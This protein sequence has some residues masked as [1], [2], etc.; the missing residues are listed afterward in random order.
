[1]VYNAMIEAFFV[2]EMP[3]LAISLLDEMIDTSTSVKEPVVRPDVSTLSDFRPSAP[4]T[5]SPSTFSTII[6]GFCNADDTE[7]AIVWFKR[8]LSQKHSPRGI[9][10]STLT[11]TRPGSVKQMSLNEL[12]TILKQQNLEEID[13]LE[14]RTVDRALIF[15]ANMKKVQE[16]IDADEKLKA[17]EHLDRLLAW[18]MVDPTSMRHDQMLQNLFK[19]FYDAAQQIPLENSRQRANILLRAFV[20][21]VYANY[22]GGLP[23]DEGLLLARLVSREVIPYNPAQAAELLHAYATEGAKEKLSNMDLHDLTTLLGV[24][25]YLE[26]SHNDPVQRGIRNY[27]FQGLFSLLTD[28]PKDKLKDVFTA[29]RPSTLLEPALQAHGFDAVREW[30]AHLDPSF[31]A[32]LDSVAT[33]QASE[34]GESVSSLP[35]SD[36]TAPTS[37]TS[38]AAQVY[39]APKYFVDDSLTH[40]LDTYLYRQLDEHSLRQ[41]C[42]TLVKAFLDGLNRQVIPSPHSVGKLCA[43]LGRIGDIQSAKMI[44]NRMQ[45]VIATTEGAEQAEIWFL[46]EDSMLIALAQAGD[47]DGAHESQMHNVV[48]NQYL[49]NNI[50]S[51]LA[52]ARK[53]EQALVLFKEM[54]AKDITPSSITY[55]ALIGACARVG[56]VESAENLFEEMVMQPKFKPR[57]PPYNT[58]MQLYTT[59]KPNKE[60]ALS[61]YYAML[62]AK[63]KP[64]PYTYKLLMD[65]H[66]L[67]P[68]DI[69]QV[70]SVFQTIVNSPV[71]ELQAGH[72]ATLINAYGCIMKDLDK[73]LQIYHTM[74]SYPRAP[75]ME[76]HF[77]HRRMDPPG[78]HMTA[79][80]VNSIIR[81]HALTGALEEARELFETLVDPPTGVAA[82][83]NHASHDPTTAVP[84]NPMEPV[85][86]EPSTWEVMV[87]AEL[88]AGH[89]DRAIALLERLKTRQYPEA[90]FNRISGI[91]VD[92][93]QIPMP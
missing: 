87:R 88:G 33:S 36:S 78:V 8:L 58:M 7:S 4:P 30:A 6:A 45:P 37:V 21:K 70:E 71:I 90:V 63:V 25:A 49:Y 15:D 83:H 68:V 26:P 47:I 20:K 41:T 91:L 38:E 80:V 48:P 13:N 51:K 53:A 76:A 46:V 44:Y 32:A 14:L 85:Y 18:K 40:R 28:L 27:A 11:P 17:K 84:V 92:H 35:L 89:R 79:Y 82:S 42:K 75:P 5:P 10:Q 31:R 73:A 54:R 67:E 22:Q 55:G 86:R 43:T 23:F 29:I 59:T 2:C 56:D 16:L 72:F 60:R 34:D 93:S 64:S 81:G 65:V 12:V 9:H 52:K 77:T 69:Q 3:D 61:Y 57:V 1:M 62:N 39:G 74:S 66:V 50:I 24:A 19:E